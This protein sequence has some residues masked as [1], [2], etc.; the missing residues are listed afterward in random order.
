MKVE[1]MLSCLDDCVSIE[2]K[3]SKRNLMNFIKRLRIMALRL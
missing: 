1:E 3:N 2:F